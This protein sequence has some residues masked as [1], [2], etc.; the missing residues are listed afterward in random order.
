MNTTKLPKKNKTLRRW[1]TWL[2]IIA[3]IVGGFFYLQYQRRVDAEKTLASLDTVSLARETLLS[4]ISGTGTV[5]AKQT[6]TLTWQTSGSIGQVMVKAG[7]TVA[8]GDILMSLDE[9][10]LP[11]DVR[12]S[13][14]ERLNL[15]Q[16]LAQIETN[17]NV[18][19]AKLNSD[20]ASAKADQ[21]TIE[22]QL[23]LWQARTCTEWNLRNLQQA[24]D[25]AYE[26]YVENPSEFNLA[27]VTQARN[28]LDF[29][30]PETINQKVSELQTQL[31]LQ[32]QSITQI[33]ENLA[34]IADGPDPDEM[35][36]LNLQLDIV[37]KRL[38]SVE[39]KAP[40]GGVVSSIVGMAGDQVSMGKFAAQIDD[41]SELQVDVPIAEVD[42]P[43][44]QLGQ[45]ANLI[46]DAYYEKTYAAKVV[47]IDRT[48][49]SVGGVMNYHVKLQIQPPFEDIKPDMT[50]GV[51][52]I[53]GEK[54]DVWAV[55]A[56]AIT[57]RDGKQVVY[58][59]RDGEPQSVEVTTGAY[60]DQKIEIIAADLSEGETI[61]LSPP[62]SLTEMFTSG[63]FL[64]R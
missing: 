20:L 22:E 11:L 27:K 2:L 39:I 5:L 29:C 60:S 63:N 28:N 17:T 14:L 53:V 59:L 41:L 61:L 10:D 40:I 15:E 38:E 51:S 18:Q 48:G 37:N 32:K 57:T 25:D 21:V 30:S 64:G 43:H 33:E 35:E 47:G 13:R 49:M 7:D 42:I 3:I 45:N 56:E 31:D 8:K 52:I 23:R 58:V 24:Y 44:I 16:A 12:Q 6:A 55:P 19:R 36:K 9:N 50:A 54:V 4:T 34:K 26:A 46:F 62:S 1:I